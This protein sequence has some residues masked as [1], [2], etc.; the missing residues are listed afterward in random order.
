MK[1]SYT[2]TRR[3]RSACGAG[4][5]RGKASALTRGWLDADLKSAAT[6]RAVDRIDHGGNF[7]PF[8]VVVEVSEIPCEYTDHVSCESRHR[9]G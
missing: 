7:G 1:S 4:A 6:D 2:D 8:F 3:L 5:Q 9:L